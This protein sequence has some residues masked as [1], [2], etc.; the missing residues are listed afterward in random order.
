MSDPFLGARVRRNNLIE[1]RALAR[2]D[3]GTRR[4][5]GT[6]GLSGKTYGV[7][8]SRDDVHA[9]LRT[10]QEYGGGATRAFETA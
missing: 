3:A 9:R 2:Y 1:P 6:D 4:T 7:L 10:L 8:P 5:I